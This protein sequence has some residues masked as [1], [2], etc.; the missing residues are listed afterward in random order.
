[1]NAPLTSEATLSM[2]PE[3]AERLAHILE[4][5]QTIHPDALIVYIG[6]FNPFLDVDESRAT[7]L[8]IAEWNALAYTAVHANPNAIMA[9]VSD[10]FELRLDE[11]LS[12]DH[13]HPNAEGYEQI[14]ARLLQALPQ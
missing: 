8:A 14:A 13:F 3:P 12:S 9:P 6:L 11:R 5:L 10:L 4:R 7:S 2:I 1:M